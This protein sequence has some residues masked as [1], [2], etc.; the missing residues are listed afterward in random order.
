M[1]SL[2]YHHVRS[3]LGV[4]DDRGSYAEGGDKETSQDEVT[5]R[6]PGTWHTQQSN[7]LYA[8]IY[9]YEL[10]KLSAMQYKVWKDKNHK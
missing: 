3:S 10:C 6:T 2:R 5:G 8:Q 7:I 4:R 1:I 9:L